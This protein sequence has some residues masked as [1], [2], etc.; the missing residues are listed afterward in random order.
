M[1]M[2]QR[3]VEDLRK[4]LVEERENRRKAP[5]TIIDIKDYPDKVIIAIKT[6]YKAVYTVFYNTVHSHYYDV[7]YIE[8]LLITML[9]HYPWY[10]L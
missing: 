8:I 1:D 6:G 5:F 4:Q 10:Y 7:G 3:Q 9:F 2:L